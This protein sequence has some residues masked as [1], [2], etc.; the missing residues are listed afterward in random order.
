MVDN[1][2]NLMEINESAIFYL[3]VDVIQAIML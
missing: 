3:A 1:K 2:I